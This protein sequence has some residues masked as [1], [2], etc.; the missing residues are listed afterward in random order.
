VPG[1]DYRWRGK[2]YHRYVVAIDDGDQQTQRKDT[3]KKAA[4]GLLINDLRDVERFSHVICPFLA[5]AAAIA[6]VNAGR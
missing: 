1:L 6:A 3:E 4:D 5:V 2:R